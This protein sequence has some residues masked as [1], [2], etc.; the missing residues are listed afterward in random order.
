MFLKH[1]L[2]PQGNQETPESVP[3]SILEEKY[4]LYVCELSGL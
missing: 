2:F 1:Y 4:L 3:T